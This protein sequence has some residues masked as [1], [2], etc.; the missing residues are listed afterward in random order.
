MPATKWQRRSLYVRVNAPW[1]LLLKNRTVKRH[2]QGTDLYLPWCHL[3]PDYARARPTYGQ[4]LV[5]LAVALEKRL[6]PDAAP[7]SVLDVGANVGDSAAQIMAATSARV[8]CIEADPYWSAYLHMNLDSN[9]RAVIEEAMLLP[10]DDTWS[11]GASPVR[12]GGTT[13]FV[14]SEAEGSLP[15]VS[16][17]KLRAQHPDFESLRLVKS[18]TDGFDTRLVPAVARAWADSGPVL[19]FEFDPGLTR[20]VAGEDPNLIWDSLRD[21]GYA[22][23]AIWDNAGDPLGQLDLADA[24][25]EART[26][27]P[28]PVHLGYDFWDVAACREDDEAALAVFDDLVKDAFSPLGVAR[29]R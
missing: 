20:Q 4:N 3:L 9:P 24:A 12:A 25:T 5:E 13:H 23:L 26:L 29:S 2:V 16:V 14:A 1:R 19:F 6:G 22:R 17:N 18:D 10:N 8:L 7:M 27:E 21:L 15:M 28:R 11:G